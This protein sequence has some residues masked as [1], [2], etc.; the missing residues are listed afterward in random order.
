MAVSTAAAALDYVVVADTPNAQRCVDLLRQKSLGVA[1]FLILDKQAHLA[2]KAG[3]K[4]VPPEG[5]RPLP[6]TGA[7]AVQ[8]E[9]LSGQS[10]PGFASTACGI[11]ITHVTAIGAGFERSV[12]RHQIR[13]AYTGGLMEPR[14]GVP[15]VTQAMPALQVWRGC[16][17]WCACA[18]RSTRRRSSTRWATPWSRPTWS[19]PRASPTRA[20]S[21]GRAS[22]RCRRGPCAPP[23]S[24]DLQSG[25]SESS[26]HCL[27]ACGLAMAAGRSRSY[28]EAMLLHTI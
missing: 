28:L 15:L 7:L 6:A 16:S 20:T 13:H 11:M 27:H 5:A 2:R 10:P 1:T 22:S 8:P 26:C 25:G 18:A 14:D 21:A 17:T 4:A 23:R 24:P 19:R 12:C 3:E 9:D